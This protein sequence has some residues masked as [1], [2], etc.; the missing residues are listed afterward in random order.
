MEIWA[1]FDNSS[2]T[3]PWTSF[4]ISL[5][6]WVLMPLALIFSAWL[7]IHLWLAKKRRTQARQSQ[8]QVTPAAQERPGV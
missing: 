4:L 8:E 7:P 3:V 5:P 1:G 2:D 6:W